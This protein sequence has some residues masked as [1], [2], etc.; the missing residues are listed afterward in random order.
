MN[1]SFAGW[2]AIKH[3]S[4]QCEQRGGF[5]LKHLLG[6]SGLPMTAAWQSEKPWRLNFRQLQT[7]MLLT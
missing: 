2:P 4:V 1:V 3:I 5:G 7:V 6:V